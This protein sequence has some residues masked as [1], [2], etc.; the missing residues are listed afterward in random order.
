VGNDGV[1]VF[2]G[3][4]SIG[5]PPSGDLGDDGSFIGGRKPGRTTRRWSLSIRKEV[6]KDSRHS[7]LPNTKFGSN[8]TSGKTIGS[9]GDDVFL[10]SRG[11]GM[12]VEL[13]EPES[14]VTTQ[15]GLLH[16]ANLI[17]RTGPYIVFFQPT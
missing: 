5:R 15:Y 1:D 11:D 14:P 13:G 7:R 16:Y 12:H 4:N 17:R 8:L 3:L 10:L 6:L 2:G 9:K